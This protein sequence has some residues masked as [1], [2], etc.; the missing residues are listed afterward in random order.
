MLNKVLLIISCFVLLGASYFSWNNR[1]KLINTRLEKNKITT[2]QVSPAK[3]KYEQIIGDIE[4]EQSIWKAAVDSKREKATALDAAKKNITSK[5]DEIAKITQEVESKQA[6]VAKMEAESAALLGSEGMSLDNIQETIEILT[7][8]ITGLKTEAETQAKELDIVQAKA[9]ENKGA[10][11]V[12]RKS[13]QKRTQALSLNS[14]EG[15]VLSSNGEY[16][17]A[18]INLGQDKGITSADR[19]IV[20][21]G[22][23]RIGLLSVSTVQ[24]GRTIT[25]IVQNSIT[26]GFSVEP[27]DRVILEKVLR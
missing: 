3:K 1:A 25:D 18:V 5:T 12:L 27:G 8:E 22:D 26:P 16:G 10:A 11:E 17:F 2:E 7:Q 15:R 23:Q 24:S 20:K 13:A 6:E 21:R 19:L 14:M 9:N 4:N